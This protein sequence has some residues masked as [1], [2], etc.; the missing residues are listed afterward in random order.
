MN[1]SNRKERPSTAHQYG[2]LENHDLNLLQLIQ[3]LTYPWANRWDGDVRSKN[4]RP[5]LQQSASYWSG[6]MT[7]RSVLH[8]VNI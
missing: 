1:G 3:W 7:H 4:Q 5:R 6:L 8:E 2:S